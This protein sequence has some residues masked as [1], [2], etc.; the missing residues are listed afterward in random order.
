MCKLK[1]VCSFL[2]RGGVHTVTNESELIYIE[3]YGDIN[4][5]SSDLRTITPILR[6]TN[7]AWRPNCVYWSLSTRDLLIG[8]YDSTITKTGK[9]IRYNQTGT[10]TQTIQHDNVGLEL[11]KCP[12]YLTEN[13]NG[14]IVVSI[15]D[16]FRM[17]GAVI[18]TERGGR[19]RFSYYGHPS[20]SGLLPLG[21]CTDALSHILIC[22]DKTKTVHML[23][24]DG[25]FISHLQIESK[26]IEKPRSLSYDFN[27]H[28]L[29]IGSSDSNTLVNYGFITRQDP[30]NS[31]S[32]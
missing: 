25:Q 32:F 17:S 5:L 15:S 13:I 4:K 6:L 9:V 16:S 2:F 22:D 27:T 14:D 21:V 29:W 18:V 10:L 31:T 30:Q 28:H 1:D 24:R 11:F 19:H 8:I 20:E 23:D 3:R 26:D 7:L 12:L